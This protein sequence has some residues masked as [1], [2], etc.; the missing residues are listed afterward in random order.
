MDNLTKLIILSKAEQYLKENPERF[1]NSEKLLFKSHL[2][3]YL[4]NKN[5]NIVDD[6]VY[7]FLIYFN[8][9]NNQNRHIEFAKYLLKKYSPHSHPKILDVGAGRLCH[10]SKRLAKNN[11][12][13]TA[14]DPKIKLT[15]QE[16]ENNKIYEAIIENFYCDEYA[17]KNK[18]GTNITGYDLLVALVPCDA[19]EHIIRQCLKYNKKFEI[20]PCAQNHQTLEK[21]QKPIKTFEDWYKY[22]ESISKDISIKKTNGLY[23]ATNNPTL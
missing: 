5:Y 20:V 8:F 9:I 16:I 4:S 12:Q 11:F 14:I 23:I 18:N 3:I 6:D 17:P 13:V 19:T 22:L 21:P 15:Q 10:L 1:D 7:D 2:N